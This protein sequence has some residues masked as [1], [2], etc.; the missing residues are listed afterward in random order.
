MCFLL[1]KRGQQR[2][3]IVKKEKIPVYRGFFFQW[4]SNP[5]S[6]A[7]MVPT[8][9]NFAASPSYQ[10][11]FWVKVK[12]LYHFDQFNSH[13][14]Q[15]LVFCRKSV[16]VTRH[17]GLCRIDP[18]CDKAEKGR[19]SE[20]QPR[21]RPFRRVFA[22]FASRGLWPPRFTTK[23]IKNCPSGPYRVSKILLG[24][25]HWPSVSKCRTDPMCHSHR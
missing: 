7:Y 25:G 10:H 2:I 13:A 6:H 5:R 3:D 9:L 21:F 22:F 11:Y 23:C 8:Y 24:H 16:L 4:G 19:N 12:I 17:Q 15:A 1:S 18:M 14:S 20:I